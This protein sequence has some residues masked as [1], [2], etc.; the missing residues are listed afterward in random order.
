MRRWR[1]AACTYQHE[2]SGETKRV[3]TWLGP[4]PKFSGSTVGVLL[5][6]RQLS[7]CDYGF[8]VPGS[9]LE[10]A[11]GLVVVQGKWVEVRKYVVLPVNADHLVE[12][13]LELS[14]GQRSAEASDTTRDV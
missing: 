10:E 2:A 1:G 11:L 13:A 7:I 4:D 8:Y 6:N 5:K 9:A 3:S 14:R 12:Q